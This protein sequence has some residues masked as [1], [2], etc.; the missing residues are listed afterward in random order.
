MLGG[1]FYS[2]CSCLFV[3]ISHWW[4][5]ER[6]DL[7]RDTYLRDSSLHLSQTEITTGM[8][9]LVTSV[10]IILCN[11]VKR[12][13]L[14]IAWNTAFCI[15][16]DFE[17]ASIRLDVEKEMKNTLR[18]T[19]LFPLSTLQLCNR[20]INFQTDSSATLACKP[21]FQFYMR[22]VVLFLISE[23]FSKNKWLNNWLSYIFSP[24]CLI[25]FCQY[26]YKVKG[27]ISYAKL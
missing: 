5:E 10:T 3:F 2:R 18:E 17:S 7:L 15:M 20:K 16:A 4:H 14:K 27:Y 23:F 6:C 8:C 26:I 1:P 25:T 24:M 12:T 22:K 9:K 21:P 19:L 13:C 11:L